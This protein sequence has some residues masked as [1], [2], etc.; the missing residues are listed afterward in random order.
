MKKTDARRLTAETQE[1]LRRQA[2][3]LKKDGKGFLEIAGI[4][5]VHRNTVST[6]WRLYEQEGSKGLT[7]KKR[8]VAPGSRRTLSP[9]QEKLIQQLIT[10]KTPDQFKLV[11][12]LWTREAVQELIQSRFD[13]KMPIRTVGEYLKRWGF[14]P[15]KPLKRAYEQRPAEVKKWLDEGYPAIAARARKEKAEI[16]WGD[17]T[18]VRSDCQHGRGYSPK[19]KTPVIRLSAKRS[20]INM[21]STVTNRGKVRFM[22]YEGSMNAERFIKFIKQLIKGAKSKIF[23]ILDNLRVHH[24]KVVKDWLEDYQDRIELF[25][26]PAYSPEL[27][28]D[29]YLNCDLKAGIHSKSPARDKESLTNKVR[30]HMKMLQRSPKR[31]RK[32][33]KHQKIS[34][35]A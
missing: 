33:F 4:V 20:S 6:W 23:L 2:I 8:G 32:Y 17:E 16:H 12:A 15:Q 9:E 29:E 24:A 28:P 10:E 34:Y 35:A 1:Q 30:S 13:I 26:L 21:I 19:G 7:S 11:F 3:R 25:F 18:G 22:V 31:V 14:T 5:G 27:N